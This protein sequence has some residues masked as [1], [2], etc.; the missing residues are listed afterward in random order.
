[1]TRG[2][3]LKASLASG[4]DVAK[5]LAV[6]WQVPLVGVHHMQAHSLTPRLVSALDDSCSDSSSLHKDYVQSKIEPEFPYLSL[7]VSGG[8]TLLVH[9]KSL[10]AHEILADTI[11]IAVGDCLDKC[12]RHILPSSVLAASPDTA[13]GRLLENF[14]FSDTALQSCYGPLLARV[15]EAKPKS[16]K[17]GWVLSTPL[18]E[19]RS[20]TKTKEMA[21]S[22]TGTGSTVQR[23]IERRLKEKGFMA[24]SER[25]D[26][27]YETMRILFEHLASRACQALAKFQEEGAGG[28]QTLVVSGGVASNGFLRRLLRTFLDCRGFAHV[29]LSFPP[30]ELCVDNAAMIGWAGTEMLEAGW[31]SDLSIRALRKWSI[32]LNAEDGGILGPD[33]WKRR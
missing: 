26:L 19:A 7:L 2:P 6:A 20:G 27:G 16:S 17:W 29:H 25:R 5:G 21:F 4:L 12:A 3:G 22:F 31:E 11:D 32:D 24:D 10:T 8:H 1:M 13:Y 9:T 30:A 14:V 23:I 18:A 15:D 28:L 33:G